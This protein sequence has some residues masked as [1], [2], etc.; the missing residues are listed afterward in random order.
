MSQ[1]PMVLNIRH[2]SCD[3]YHRFRQDSC[4]V[5]SE[6]KQQTQ[7]TEPVAGTGA[8]ITTDSNV[9]CAT[10]LDRQ[11]RF[12]LVNNENRCHIITLFEYIQRNPSCG[13]M[14]QVL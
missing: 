9:K 1:S 8:S 3:V 12:P 10:S 7:T 11:D 2:R 4:R 5:A 13:T 14:I 6:L